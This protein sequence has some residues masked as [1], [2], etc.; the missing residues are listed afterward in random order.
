MRS[1]DFSRDFANNRNGTDQRTNER[2]DER[3]DERTVGRLG[4]MELVIRLSLVCQSAQAQT[5]EVSC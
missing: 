3:T 4:I 5:N 2:T 1:C